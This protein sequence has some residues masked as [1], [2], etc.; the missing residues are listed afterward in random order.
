MTGGPRQ[1]KKN[2]SLTFGVSE[3]HS[4]NPTSGRTYLYGGLELA[5]AHNMPL[6]ACSERESAGSWE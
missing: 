3:N 2:I 1:K 5:E 4:V 6:R